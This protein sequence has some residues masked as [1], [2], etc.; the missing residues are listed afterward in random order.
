M[1]RVITAACAL[2]LAAP[3]AGHAN[4]PQEG[5]VPFVVDGAVIGGLS[6]WGL[7]LPVGDAWQRVCEEAIG[8]VA[9][10]SRRQGNGDILVGALDG[11]MVTRDQ[12]CSYQLVSGAL[13]GLAPSALVEAGGRLFATTGQFGAQNG[14][15]VSDDGAASWDPATTPQSELLL[16]RLIASPDGTHLMA[17]GSRSGASTAP[18]VLVSTDG[19]DSFADASAGYSAYVIATALGFLEDGTT[20]MISGITATNDFRVLRA[21]ADSYAAPTVI[22]NLPAEAK[23]GVAW[24]GTVWVVTPLSGDLY[25]KR[26]TD[27][28]FVHVTDARTGPTNCI[29]LHPSGDGLM[30]CGRQL[31]GS[32]GLFMESTDGATWTELIGFDD[33]SYRVCSAETTGFTACA[34]YYESSCSNGG[35][36]DFDQLIDCDDDDCLGRCASE[37]EGEGEGD[38]AEGEGE[39]DVGEGEGEGEQPGCRCSGASGTGGADLALAL[40]A[41]GVLSRWRRRAPRASSA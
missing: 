14:V 15:F 3:A 22:G 7:V 9:F 26:T 21:D 8:P 40:V 34:T 4:Q 20:A 30:G 41:A 11:L 37:G 32:P 12:G 1:D 10:F 38:P 29:Y 31:P 25:Q 16:F 6:T 24:Q 19:G 5:R 18:V 39:G 28:D 27:G 17:T 35:D 33:V 23:Y 13:D 36:E 2:L